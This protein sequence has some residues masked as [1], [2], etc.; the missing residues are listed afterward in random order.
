MKAQEELCRNFSGIDWRCLLAQVNGASMVL[1]LSACRVGKN[2][3]GKDGKL[4][5]QLCF[6]KSLHKVGSSHWPKESWA[7]LKK[8][9]LI[10]YI[11]S[12]V[13]QRS[14]QDIS[15]VS[16]LSFVNI[17]HLGCRSQK[18]NNSPFFL[19]IF[20]EVREWRQLHSAALECSR[21]QDHGFFDLGVLK[22]DSH[23]MLLCLGWGCGYGWHGPEWQCYF[24]VAIMCLV[25]GLPK[26]FLGEI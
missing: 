26:F 9:S 7:P 12:Y 6:T 8:A 19:R 23:N 5:F 20:L 4:L 21:G 17:R 10:L 1:Q 25:S 15:L 2:A 13:L 14:Y 22:V 11:V 24:A 16:L 3:L 18:Q